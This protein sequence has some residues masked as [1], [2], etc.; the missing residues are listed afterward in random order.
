VFVTAVLAPAGLVFAVEIETFSVLAAFMYV[1][2]DFDL[3][4]WLIR[5]FKVAAIA[6]AVSSRQ[7]SGPG[8][9]PDFA[10]ESLAV[11]EVVV[12]LCEE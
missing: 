4:T 11:D 8:W 1:Q 12:A 9:K 2:L 6:C 10:A 3:L 7:G 5:T